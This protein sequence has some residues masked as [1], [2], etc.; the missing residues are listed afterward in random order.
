MPGA[1][2]ILVMARDDTSKAQI[3]RADLHHLVW[4]KPL[5]AAAAELGLSA[6]GL[7]KICDRAN[8]PRPSRQYW[9]AD[10][11]RKIE[12]D[13]LGDPPQEFTEPIVIGQ[14]QPV[15]KSRS[16]LPLE[17]RQKQ[18]A[19]EAVKIALEAGVQKVTIKEVARRTGISEAQA[20]NCF[21]R[22]ID[23]LVYVTRREIAAMETDRVDRTA[24][25]H[26]RVG[27]IVISTISYLHNAAARGPLLQMLLRD[28]DIRRE[29][30]AE[31]QEA[32]DAARVEIT[33]TLSL[34]GVRRPIGN[35]TTSSLSALT[36]RT[37][38][39][40]ASGRVD[41][42]TAERLCVAIVMAGVWTPERVSEAASSQ[43]P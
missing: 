39:L 10:D 25:G 24:R 11:R 27:R 34:M 15:R 13:P 33:D 37:G 22:R 31:R 36:L 3:T 5:A 29:L 38:G 12:P 26:D 2:T 9:H 16:R 17:V 4:T 8:V 20:H 40:I 14:R 6:N 35:A 7:A 28:P 30:Q 32:A 42:K 43:K 1:A 19:D 23:M 21:K 41:L 18:L